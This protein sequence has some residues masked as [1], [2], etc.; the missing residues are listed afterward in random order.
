MKDKIK[1]IF[2]DKK[3]YIY[4]LITMLFFGVLAK[5]EF[6]TDSYVVFMQP[7][8][9]YMLWFLKSGRF[10]S[11]LFLG[12]CRF[13]G[14]G[15][16]LRMY[17][18][19]FI[20]AIISTTF[21]MYVVFNIIKDAVKNNLLKFIIPVLIVINIFSIELYM[22][23][24]KGIMMASV[25]FD[26][27]AVYWFKK[28]LDG[29]NKLI[30]LSCFMMLLANFSYQGTVGLFVLFSAVYVIKSS[31]NIK[32]FLINNI[33]LGVVYLVP[34]VINYV[35][36]KV[37]FHNSRVSGEFNIFESIHRIINESIQMITKTYRII[38]KYLFFWLLFITICLVLFV[39]IKSKKNLKYKIF[40]ILSVFYLLILGGLA[41]VAPQIMQSTNAI[42]FA[43]RNTYTFAS[44]IGVLFLL[45]YVFDIDIYN[46]IEYILICVAIIL[47]SLQYLNFSDFERDRYIINYNDNE[48]GRVIRNKIFDYECKNHIMIKNVSFYTKLINGSSYTY[49]NI[50]ISGDVNLKAMYPDWAREYFIKYILNGRDINVKNPDIDVYNKYFYNK[51]F[52]HFT[53]DQIVFE[54]DCMYVYVY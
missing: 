49:P 39:I 11:A 14:I 27:L 13:L 40:T 4:F 20:I 18:V 1:R 22:F 32:A 33:Y 3:L 52:D 35:I 45:M 53:D 23:M 24:E 41:T 10:I 30:F 38:P 26:V 19:S 17:T 5:L 6:A 21:A 7:T 8:K 36:V 54:N 29:D 37:F 34:A 50:R 28:F 2:I 9:Q 25:L 12:F 44:F 46:Y 16:P 31:K 51:Y 47:I 48:I 42:G 43:A 15:S